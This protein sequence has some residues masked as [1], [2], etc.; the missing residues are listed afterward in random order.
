MWRMPSERAA[1]VWPLGTALT[2]ARRTS[3]RT[4]EAVMATGRAIIQKEAIFTPYCG[5]TRKKK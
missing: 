1:S 4:P 2:P 5:T 3:A